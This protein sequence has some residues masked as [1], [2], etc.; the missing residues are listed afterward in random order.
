MTKGRFSCAV[1]FRQVAFV[2]RFH[3]DADKLEKLNFAR[4]A[5]RKPVKGMGWKNGLIRSL[6]IS[7]NL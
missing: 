1:R 4:S 6:A 3:F 7:E 2:C 5:C